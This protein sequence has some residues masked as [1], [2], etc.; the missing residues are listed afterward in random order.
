[1]E[2][3]YLSNVGQKN[4]SQAKARQSSQKSQ[5]QRQ[6]FLST[7]TFILLFVLKVHIEGEK[8]CLTICLDEERGEENSGE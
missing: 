7:Y 8:K 3:S 4:S 5:S 1:M 6:K 2:E